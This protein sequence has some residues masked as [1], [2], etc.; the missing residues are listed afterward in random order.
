MWQVPAFYLT[1][2]PRTIEESQGLGFAK[3]Q[4]REKQEEARD[5]C[6]AQVSQYQEESLPQIPFGCMMV[7]YGMV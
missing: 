5:L 7:M 6:A 4:Q 2:R 1:S 3:Q